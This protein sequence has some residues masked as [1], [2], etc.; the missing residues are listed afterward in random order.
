MKDGANLR[1]FE[2]PACK[3][4]QFI[5][6]I[7]P[8]YYQPKKEIIV[9]TSPKDLKA[10]IHHAQEYPKETQKIINAGYQKTLNHHTFINRFKTLINLL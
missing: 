2:I 5:D 7:N 3:T 4:L 6:K 10:K 8:R 1:T 9:F